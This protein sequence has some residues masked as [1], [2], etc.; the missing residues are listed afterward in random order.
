MDGGDLLFEDP[1]Y[2]S[3]LRL[4]GKYFSFSFWKV[5]SA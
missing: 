5:P 1:F 4:K 2:L 3:R